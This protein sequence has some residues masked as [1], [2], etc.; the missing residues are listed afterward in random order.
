M[1]DTIGTQRFVP[2]RR[3][4]P[5]SGASGM[6]PVSVVPRNRAVEHNVAVFFLL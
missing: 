1:T 3:G 4:V 5:N 2:Y 6:L